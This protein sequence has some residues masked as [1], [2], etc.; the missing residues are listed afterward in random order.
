[1]HLRGRTKVTTD[2]PFAGQEI[3]QTLFFI[4][5]DGKIRKKK[6]LFSEHFFFLNSLY[7]AKYMG[8]ASGGQTLEDN[9]QVDLRDIQM[10]AHLQT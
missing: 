5:L 9:N 4:C 1:M 2:W 7:V 10:Y 8:N 3:Q 6:T